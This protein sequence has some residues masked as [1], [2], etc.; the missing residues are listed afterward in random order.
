MPT[1]GRHGASCGDS[2][3]RSSV[4]TYSAVAR[5]S[6]SVFTNRSWTPSSHLRRAPLGIG[7]LGHA[8]AASRAPSTAG[9]APPERITAAFRAKAVADIGPALRVVDDQCG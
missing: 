2:F 1:L 6:R 5:V 4:F 9:P 3:S 8:G 7:R